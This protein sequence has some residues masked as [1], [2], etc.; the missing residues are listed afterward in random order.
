MLTKFSTQHHAQVIQ[1][2]GMNILFRNQNPLLDLLID[3]SYFYFYHLRFK[4]YS[5]NHE[6]YVNQL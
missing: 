5:I 1:V 2:I 6:K 3:N 4:F